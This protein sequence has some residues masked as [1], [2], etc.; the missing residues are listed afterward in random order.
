MA[1]INMGSDMMARLMD[2]FKSMGVDDTLVQNA[3]SQ[4]AQQPSKYRFL[5]AA[6][7]TANPK[8]A[9]KIARKG[10][11]PK[12]F[13]AMAKKAQKAKKSDGKRIVVGSV[14][15]NAKLF[16]D[17][18]GGKLGQQTLQELYSILKD[19]DNEKTIAAKVKQFT[20][21]KDARTVQMAYAFLESVL[22]EDDPIA[23]VVHKASVAHRTANITDITVSSDL[24]EAA[25]E[26]S[27]GGITSLA[28]PE[29]LNEFFSSI[30]N[31]MANEHQVYRGWTKTYTDKEFS[32]VSKVTCRMIGKSIRDLDPFAEK[33]LIFALTTATNRMRCYLH[34][35]NFF[36]GRHKVIDSMKS[37]F[38]GLGSE[39]SVPSHL[40]ENT[41]ASPKGRRAARRRRP[42]APAPP[43]VK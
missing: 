2:A 24:V 7:A 12:K 32:L 3:L 26:L 28:T 37:Y 20:K 27:K 19:D 4:A 33:G 5:V 40:V 21:G 43:K 11:D 38:K 34:T 22:P 14:K 29:Q 10:M 36:K 13:K 15:E 1:A 9:G 35:F 18:S 31:E 8:F 17:A 39:V 25:E 16:Q 30:L 23:E 41:P 6:M 42:S